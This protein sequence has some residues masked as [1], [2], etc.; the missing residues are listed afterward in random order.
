MLYQ[1]QGGTFFLDEI[2][3]MPLSMQVKLLRVM[4]EKEFVPVGGRKTIKMDIRFI[5]T[6]NRNL[7]EEMTKG[8]FREDLFYRIYVIAIQLPPLRERKGDIPVLSHYFLDKLSKDMDKKMT[9]FSS[10]AAC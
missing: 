2:S 5:A 9:G 10:G 1:A 4:Q 8:N 7:K 6:S 3:E